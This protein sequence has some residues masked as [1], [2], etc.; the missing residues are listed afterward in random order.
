MAKM[1]HNKK[2]NTAFLYEA[3][4]RDLTKS[5]LSK[6]A[7]RQKVLVGVLR[8]HF[9]KGALLA[10]ELELYRTIAEATSL[11][12]STA[13]RLLNE[14]KYERSKIDDQGLFDEQTSLIKRINK[15]LSKDVYANF[16]PHYKSLATIAQLFNPAVSIKKRVILEE[17]LVRRIS[18]GSGVE[19]LRTADNVVYGAFIKRFNETYSGLFEEQ[20]KLLSA[21]VSSFADNG[22]DLKIYLNE[23]IGR[24][25]TRIS[26]AMNE[27]EIKEDESMTNKTQEIL[28]LLEGFGTKEINPS[29]LKKVLKIQNLVRE[30]DS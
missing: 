1:R 24:L 5:I 27:T 13:Q 11:P 9:K 19:E 29:L 20:Q 25:K 16:V 7:E 10:R 2:R 18:T 23:E 22:L 26:V 30:L 8:E 6:D 4:I 21:Y 15:R 17:N 28:T 14:I 3:L 12:A